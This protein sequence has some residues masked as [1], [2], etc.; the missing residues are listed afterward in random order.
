MNW[1]LGIWWHSVSGTHQSC[2]NH[3][4]KGRKKRNFQVLEVKGKEKENGNR[5]FRQK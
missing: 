2:I 3:P 5:G 4:V 1:R